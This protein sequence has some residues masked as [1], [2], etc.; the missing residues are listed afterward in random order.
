MRV[1]R[2]Y[3]VWYATNMKKVIVGMSGGVDSSVTAYLLKEQ[4]YEVEGVSFILYEARMKNTFTGCCSIEVINDARR[5]AEHMGVK[6]TAVDLRNEFME[7]VIEPFIEAYSKGMTPNPCI[8]CNRHIKFPYLLKIAGEK[9]ADF[10]ATGHYARVVSAEAQKYGSAEATRRK[11]SEFPSFRA[12]VLKKG[13]DN[14][15]D[16]S[17]VLY[18]LRKE[19]L[20]RLLLPLGDKR[21]DEVREIARTLNLPA[22]KRPESQEICF[23]EDRNYFRF[24]ENLTGSKEGPIIDVETGETLGTHKGIYL[25]T[26]GQRKRLGIAAGKPLFVAK[27]DPSKNAVYAGPK[28]AAMIREFDVFDINWLMSV[29]PEFRATVKVRSMMNDEPA[30]IRVLDDN[31]V[32]VVY[33]EPQWAPA[34]GQSAVF[35]DGEA[36]IGGGIIQ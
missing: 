29:G 34:P 21:K 32:N 10:I 19:E 33:D 3:I 2:D 28:E 26:V 36:V 12:S 24:L 35:Y 27:I 23:I 8:L 1:I 6:H 17:Y 22:A 16:Q 7:K 11:T 31:K 30:S 25:Y 20:N 15:K 14:K 13:I 18:V 9:G 4:G 5:T